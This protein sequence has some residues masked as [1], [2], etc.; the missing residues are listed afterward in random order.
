[1]TL[2]KHP[3]CLIENKA[4]GELLVNQDAVQ[5]L[6]DITQPVVVVSIVGKY[7]TGKS[8]LMN[9]LTGKHNGF[10]LGSTIES[11]T[12]GI[13]MWCIPH[14][15]KPGHTLVLL[16]TE[17]LGDVEKGDSKNDAWIFS[18]AV[19][20]SSTLVYNS[21]GTID[22]Q[23][24]EQLHYVTELTERIKVTAAAKES[25]CDNEDES[26]E[27]KRFFPSF[28]WC[29]RDFILKL[30]KEGDPITEDE[31]L[32]SALM[33]K[34][35]T[36]KKVQDYNLPREC[37]RHYFHSHKCF[38]FDRPASKTNLQR[39][40]DLQDS[41]LEHEFVKQAEKFC[42]YIYQKSKSKIL[43]GGYTVTGRLLGNLA[44]TYVEAIRS[45]SIPCMEN[46][47]LALAQ[48]E[49]S[50]AVQEAL[51]KYEAEMSGRVNKFPTE[52]QEEFL[53]MHQECEKE[54]TKVF[55]NLSFKD[56]KQEYQNK[57]IHGLVE[58]MTKYSQCN[59]EESSK[60]CRALLKKL[61]ERLERGIA[62][63]EYSKSGGHQHFI[64]EKESLIEAYH[65][66]PGKGIKATEALQ[67]FL[68]EK[69]EV[70]T[71][72]LQADQSLT[73][74]EKEMAEQR[75]QTEA[76]E[77]ENQILKE[78]KER[79]EELMEDQKRSFQKQKEMLEQKM[80]DERKKMMEQNEWMIQEKLKEQEAM[81][82]EG[83]HKQ[84][85]MLNDQIESLKKQNEN[86]SKKS[87]LE[88]ILSIVV[89]VISP[90]IRPFIERKLK[91]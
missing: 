72:I 87:F 43:A 90:L 16:D 86:A 1:M 61:S 45:G 4:G 7:R 59:E 82:K 12:K 67:D 88:E 24:M 81:L 5:I 69:K 66:S 78:N 27:F 75:A 79:L 68:T 37:I 17:G 29:V 42:S 40:D 57:F 51:S 54:A 53:I 28:I 64:E 41:E 32:Q 47:V 71:A 22:Q 50:R 10:A 39:M 18:L 84:Y 83:F 77:R 9:K 55:M 80:E 19:L 30:E 85:E 20:L 74:K 73:D 23:A 31:Y 33:L 91:N 26:A 44:V 49:N 65:R 6:L 38:V 58:K 2:M 35:G 14:P 21:M 13:W 46:A 8:Y 34:K 60:F 15:S 63:K 70:E 48:I 89:P 56:E 25:T 52:T 36:S 62:E 76:A 3:I 11:K